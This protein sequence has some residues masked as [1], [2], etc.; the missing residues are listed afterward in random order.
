MS[1]FDEEVFF[2]DMA[3]VPKKDDSFTMPS[4][5]SSKAD[6]ASNGLGAANKRR[7]SGRLRLIASTALITAVLIMWR[8]SYSGGR[9]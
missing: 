5:A 2:A 6:V 7:R 4:G 9:T 1:F 3:E 8:T